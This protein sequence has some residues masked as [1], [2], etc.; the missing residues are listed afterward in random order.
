MVRF[1]KRFTDFPL[2]L[3]K[4][5]EK[6]KKKKK[7]TKQRHDYVASLSCLIQS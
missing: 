4:N 1:I 5:C 6:K 3:T 7:E 2:Y